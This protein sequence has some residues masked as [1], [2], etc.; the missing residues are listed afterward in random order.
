MY[1][2]SCTGGMVKGAQILILALLL[3]WRVTLS[4]VTHSLS[5]SSPTPIVYNWQQWVLGIT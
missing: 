3:T 1:I 5:G 4:I 2:A